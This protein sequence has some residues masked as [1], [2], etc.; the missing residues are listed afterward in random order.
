[1]NFITGEETGVAGP[2]GP[3]GPVGADGV[4]GPNGPRGLV[5]A[6]GVAGPNGP[7]GPVGADGVVLA[8]VKTKYPLAVLAEGSRVVSSSNTG[9]DQFLPFRAFDGIYG[10]N[11]VSVYSNPQGGGWFSESSDTSSNLMVNGVQ[12]TGRYIYIDLRPDST[13]A[14]ITSFQIYSMTERFPVEYHL[15]VSNDTTNWTSLYH[16]EAAV[17]AGS[18]PH[19]AYSTG[20]TPEINLTS[21]YVHYRYVGVLVISQPVFL[22][23]NQ[24]AIQ[25][26]LLYSIR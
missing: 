4:A 23:G 11:A 15:I 25:E 20:Y 1:M 22:G 19:G 5:G 16:T 6:D 14:I 26:L 7:Q 17:I 18:V 21:N 9:N 13:M 8:P 10:A 24:T 2:D 12:T 3:R